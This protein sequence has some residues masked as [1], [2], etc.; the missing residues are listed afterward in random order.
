MLIEVRKRNS[1]LLLLPYYWTSSAKASH[2]SM[3]YSSYFADLETEAK[4]SS[5]NYSRSQSQG[6]LEVEIESRSV[7]AEHPIFNLYVELLMEWL[8]VS[9]HWLS[10]DTLLPCEASHLSHEDNCEYKPFND[11]D[12]AILLHISLITSSTGLYCLWILNKY[13]WLIHP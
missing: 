2:T 10:S 3:D 12:W 6:V 7:W 1:C 4:V 13:I 11:R 9:W 5:A 8:L